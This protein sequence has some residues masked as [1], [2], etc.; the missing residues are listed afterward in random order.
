M[1]NNQINCHRFRQ[2]PWSKVCTQASELVFSTSHTV[3]IMHLSMCFIS[4]FEIHIF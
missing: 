3:E 4:N 1:Q 2:F